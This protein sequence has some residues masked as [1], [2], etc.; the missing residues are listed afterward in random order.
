MNA[1]W[2][3]VVGTSA[4]AFTLKYL[5]H[6]IPEKYLTNPRMLRINTLIPIALLSALVGVQTI[7]EKGKWVIDQ[8]LAGVAVA[9]IA[10]SLKAPYFAVVISAA[11]TS[12]ALYRL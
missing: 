8:R 5:G 9:L 2:I 6:S 1:L 4:I 10:L 12:A 11:I 7:T 3:G